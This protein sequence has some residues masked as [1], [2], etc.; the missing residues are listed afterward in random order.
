MSLRGCYDNVKN[1]R[2]SVLSQ[3]NVGERRMNSYWKL[4]DPR[5]NPLFKISEKNL[6]GWGPLVHPI[7][8][9]INNLLYLLFLYTKI[10][11]YPYRPSPPALTVTHLIILYAIMW[12]GKIYDIKSVDQRLMLFLISFAN[13][14][15][16]FKFLFSALVN[17]WTQGTT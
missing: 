8:R 1:C 6:I 11:I 16:L 14:I 4:E 13:Y 10:I 9:F 17:W 5:I 15:W 3:K 2:Q 7:R 12:L